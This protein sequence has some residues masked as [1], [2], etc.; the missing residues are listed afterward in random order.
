[1]VAAL[2]KSC[3]NYR[4]NRKKV[5]EAHIH[6]ANDSAHS[7]RPYPLRTITACSN[8]ITSE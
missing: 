3:N 4:Y 2:A 7:A 6:H 1:M 5:T 8:A